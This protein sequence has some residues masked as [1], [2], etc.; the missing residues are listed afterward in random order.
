[1]SKKN[2]KTNAGWFSRRTTKAVSAR[3]KHRFGWLST[4]CL[5]RKLL[6]KSTRLQPIGRPIWAASESTWMKFLSTS[7]RCLL[8][9]GVL[10]RRC[11]SCKIVTLNLVLLRL[12]SKFCLKYEHGSSM[13]KTGLRLLA[14]RLRSTLTKIAPN[15]KRIWTV[16]C[17]FTPPM[18]SRTLWRIPAVL[19]VAR[20]LPSAAA[21]VRISG[22]APATVNSANGKVTKQC[23]RSLPLVTRK[24]PRKKTWWSSSLWSR[25]KRRS[26]S[27]TVPHRKTKNR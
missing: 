19:S 15:T 13:A 2:L 6:I 3:W 7:Y 20:L 9:C 26:P 4:I 12:W 21:N 14:T 24:R 27:A 8:R 22:T 10:L 25:P 18:F 5:W 16:W 11:S 17:T 1:M 23:A